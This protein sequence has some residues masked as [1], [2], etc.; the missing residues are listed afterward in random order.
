MLVLLAAC[1]V[2]VAGVLWLWS[3]LYHPPPF[4]CMLL[5]LFYFSIVMGLLLLSGLVIDDVCEQVR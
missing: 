2:A 1:A 5:F 3:F 4:S